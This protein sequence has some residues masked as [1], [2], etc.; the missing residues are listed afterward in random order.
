MICIV[1]RYTAINSTKGDGIMP[2]V[3]KA[4]R[5]MFKAANEAKKL[6]CM[7]VLCGY[8]NTPYLSLYGDM[9]DAI[10]ALIGE[11]PETFEDSVT[12]MAIMSDAP[13]EE[14]VDMLYNCYLANNK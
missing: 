8:S 2:D 3:R 14:R 9:A 12:Y 13:F 4:L 11:E 6:D 1:K 5:S 10:I 7:M